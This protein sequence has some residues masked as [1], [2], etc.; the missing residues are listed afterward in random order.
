MECAIKFVEP[1][2]RRRMRTTATDT[3]NPTKKHISSLC[4]EYHKETPALEYGFH[5]HSPKFR[6][7]RQSVTLLDRFHT[8]TFL[9][10]Y[11]DMTE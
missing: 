11:C 2:Q 3:E 8:S 9:R 4:V 1:E 5:E 6:A 7:T 10:D